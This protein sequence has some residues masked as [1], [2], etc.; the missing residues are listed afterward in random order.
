MGINCGYLVEYRET[1]S[2]HASIKA[3]PFKALYGRKCRSPL[4]WAEVEDAQVTS[5][6]LINKTTEN[7]VQIKQRIQ[8]ARDCQKSYANV[9]RKPLEFQVGDRVMLKVSPW[10]GVVRFGNWGSLNPRYIGTFLQGVAQSRKKPLLK[11]ELP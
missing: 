8:A 11:L 4:C 6:E 7:I 3:D 10:K 1:N 2:Y 5:P 9:R